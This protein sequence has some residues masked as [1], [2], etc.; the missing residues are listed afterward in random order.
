MKFLSLKYLTFVLLLLIPLSSAK[1]IYYSLKN[2]PVN[3]EYSPTDLSEAI[4]ALRSLVDKN[5]EITIISRKSY[6]PYYSG[7]RQV[8]LPFTT[9]EKLV[10]YARLNKVSFIYL[11]SKEIEN[12]PY[13]NLFLENKAPEFKLVYSTQDKN[14]QKIFLYKFLQ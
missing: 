12:Y 2:S 6:F 11:Q 4:E 8:G 3:K 14:G 10:K 5:K 1:P 9:Y 7:S 13:G